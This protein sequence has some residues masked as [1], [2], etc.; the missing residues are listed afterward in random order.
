ML[1]WFLR[2]FRFVRDIESALSI[3]IKETDRANDCIEGMDR[4]IDAIEIS[5]KSFEET[6]RQLEGEIR[7]I[8]SREAGK[9]EA[10]H[11]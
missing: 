8:K 6:I 10:A 5:K 3:Q 2:R 7:E 4:Y 9:G 1:R 11:G